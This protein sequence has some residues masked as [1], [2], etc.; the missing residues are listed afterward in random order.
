[1]ACVLCDRCQFALTTSRGTCQVAHSVFHGKVV[2]F[3]I[4]IFIF[5]SMYRIIHKISRSTNISMYRFTPSKD[6]KSKSMDAMGLPLGTFLKKSC[7]QDRFYRFS[8]EPGA[9]FSA[10][11]PSKF[12]YNRQTSL[13]HPPSLPS[14]M[15]TWLTSRYGLNTQPTH[16]LSR[17]GSSAQSWNCPVSS[18]C[19]HIYLLLHLTP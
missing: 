17:T 9:T 11:V 12:H 5:V 14:L 7:F 19:H 4:I 16:F 18:P 8:G 3:C 2:S 10:F 6:P 1:M 13:P 15:L